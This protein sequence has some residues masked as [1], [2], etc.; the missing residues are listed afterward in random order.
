MTVHMREYKF[1]TTFWGGF[2]LALAGLGCGLIPGLT[3]NDPNPTP[4]VIVLEGP[5]S[6][7]QPQRD[8][9]QVGIGEELLLNSYHI[10][11]HQLDHLEI[12][13]NG[14]KIRTE[15]SRAEGGT[16]PP[17]FATVQ[18]RD[19]GRYIATDSTAPL[20]PTDKW[21]VSLRWVG[22]VPGTY[23]LKLQIVDTEDQRN[24]VTQRIE[25]K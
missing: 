12:F 23:D 19:N 16:F 8:F 25:V 10:S 24:D 18:V 9:V 14:Q 22:H 4:T 5:V 13:V 6:I 3:S 2:I 15:V 17:R 21:A 7:F 11:N 1:L 20:L